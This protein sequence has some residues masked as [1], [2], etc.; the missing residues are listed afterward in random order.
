MTII[1]N[2]NWRFSRFNRTTKYYFHLIFD[3]IIYIWILIVAMKER[4][5]MNRQENNER[6]LVFVSCASLSTIFL[7]IWII[8]FIHVLSVSVEFI[9]YTL[10]SLDLWLPF[11]LCRY[12]NIVSHDDSS[13]C[14]KTVLLIKSSS[15]LN[16]GHYVLFGFL[17]LA[18]N[19]LLFQ[20]HH[21]LYETN[22][23]L[24]SKNNRDLF[25][26]IVISTSI[27]TRADNE[28]KP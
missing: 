1:V 28:K 11:F 12:H 25:V 14:N 22:K 23:F 16:L 20:I 27:N 4:K 24:S 17:M 7:A 9:F 21:I 5:K 26:F 15:T 3:R 2:V 6:N 10:E 19:G 13:K 8:P 18:V